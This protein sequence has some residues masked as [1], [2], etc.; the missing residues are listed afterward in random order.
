MRVL[1]SL[2]AALAVLVLI[3]AASAFSA[4]AANSYPTA[5]INTAEVNIRSGAGTNYSVIANPAKR[6][7]VKLLN[8]KLYNGDWYHI[9]LIG[10]QKGYVHRDYLTINKNQLYIP[11]SVT[12]YKGYTVTYSNFVNTTGCAVSW[13]SSNKKV[14]TVWNGVVTCT[15]EGT[16]TITAKAGTKSVSS[17]LTV[18]KAEVTLSSAQLELFADDD[19][20]ALNVRCAR[21]VTFSSSDTSVVTVSSGGKVT[22]VGAGTAKVYARSNSDTAICKVTIKKRVISLSVTKSTL[23][24]GC[25]S[26][27]T[28]SG[29]KS[30]YRYSSSN[31]DV[32]TVDSKGWVKGV[33]AGTAKVTVTSGDLKKVKTFTVKSNSGINITEDEATIF[34]G[35]TLYLKSASNASWSSSDTSIATVDGGF[36]YGRKK[37]RVIISASTSSG[38]RDCVVSVRNPEPVRFVY[39]SQNSVLLKNKVKLYA[40][41]DSRRTAVKFRLT[42]QSGKS[43][44]VKNPTK[45]VSGSRLIWTAETT[46]NKAGSYTIEAYSHTA[47]TTKWSTSNGGRS[48][49]F[50][51]NATTRSASNTD[52]KRATTALIKNIASFE[53]YLSNVTPDQLVADTPTVGYGRVVYEGTTFYNGMTKAEAYAYLVKT[54]NDSGFTSRVNKLLR[55]NDIRF[56]Q[57]QFDALVCFSYNLGAYALEINSEITDILKNTYGT[58]SNH[59]KGYINGEGVALRE[60]PDAG[61]KQLKSLSAYT[62]VKLVSAKVYKNKW[63]NVKVGSLTG[64]VSRSYVTRRTMDTTVRDLRNIN[65]SK[66]RNWMLARHHASGTCYWGLLYRRIDEVELFMFGDYSVDGSS[67]KYNMQYSCSGNPSFA[68]S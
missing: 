50:V 25:Y 21:P 22:P 1:K 49:F 54:V 46:M 47:A 8:A 15:G 5:H 6:S 40:I 29:G 45:S 48:T 19:P 14:G 55:E 67:N 10:G 27:I 38:E 42:D 60:S 31:T 44:W 23:Y 7:R 53:G 28:P 57:A 39:T 35:T 63:F 41:T 36:V 62:T 18:R 9:R 26:V 24:S 13:T 68:V 33:S 4:S 16:T 3:V 17:T 2:T 20:V 66:F 61:S 34:A 12:G 65:Y 51:N 64:Y 56:N 37:G 58:E 43:S 59:L 30:A 32:L 11:A 52:E